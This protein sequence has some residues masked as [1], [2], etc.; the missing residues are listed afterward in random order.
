MA[1]RRTKQEWLAAVAGS[2]GVVEEIA[3]RLGV[4]SRAVTKRKKE[5]PDFAE[6]VEEEANVVLGTAESELVK[7]I[8]KGNLKAIMWF[9]DRKGKE[10]G[11]GKQLKVDGSLEQNGRIVLHLPDD[12]RESTGEQSP[13]G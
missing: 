2:G 9:L 12:G 8:K 5:H 1:R 3:K 7:A 10:R 4:T 6:A 11:Y 13:G